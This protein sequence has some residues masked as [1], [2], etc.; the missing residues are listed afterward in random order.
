MNGNHNGK[1]RQVVE[2]TSVL[3][4]GTTCFDSETDQQILIEEEYHHNRFKNPYKLSEEIESMTEY[5]DN[6]DFTESRERR[7][8]IEDCEC[9]M[10]AINH[11][12]NVDEPCPAADTD[13]MIISHNDRQRQIVESTSVLI[14]GTT[15][16]DSETNQRILIEEEK[17]CIWFRVFYNLSE[18]FYISSFES[19]SKKLSSVNQRTLRTKGLRCDRPTFKNN[20]AVGMRCQAADTEVMHEVRDVKQRHDTECTPCLVYCTTCLESEINPMF[21]VEE[22]VESSFIGKSSLCL[23]SFTSSIH[24]QIRSFGSTLHHSCLSD[25]QITELLFLNGDT[26]YPFEMENVTSGFGL[27]QFSYLFYSI[28]LTQSGKQN[29]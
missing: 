16:L 20:S 10:K 29:L 28:G 14:D 4:D 11:H 7:S 6:I 21:S 25:H 22:F 9:G 24:F 27:K 15:C 17:H 18:I 3:I 12:P 2:S 26:I 19:I 8:K 23:L 5:R 1:Q 13:V